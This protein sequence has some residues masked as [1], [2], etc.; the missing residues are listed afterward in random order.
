MITLSNQ[1]FSAGS[2]GEGHVR[3]SLTPEWSSAASAPR[4]SGAGRC[5]W[6]DLGFP[7]C[8]IFDEAQEAGRP[9]PSTVFWRFPG[10]SFPKERETGK[11]S[12]D[13]LNLGPPRRLFPLA[14]C[15]RLNYWGL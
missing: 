14:S 7:T 1:D 6:S 4:F 3:S 2:I 9:L 12:W 15:T 13:V 5:G 8:G 11:P 10:F